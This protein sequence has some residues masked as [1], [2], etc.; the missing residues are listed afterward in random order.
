MRAW[1]LL[2]VISLSVAIATHYTCSSCKVESNNVYWDCS[3]CAMA[4]ASA[5]NK[6]VIGYL[7]GW[8]NPPAASAIAKAGYT[9]ILVAFGVFSTSQPG[10]IVSAFSPPNGVLTKSY[11]AQLQSAG[12]KVLL[13]LGGASS[14]IANTDI[15]FH[16][17]LA[18]ANSP[19][20]FI[21]A[22]VQ[23]TQQI[24]L[25]YGFDGVDFDIEAGLGPTS[26]GTIS[27]PGGDIAVLGQIIVQLHKNNP[28][29]LIS[30]V[31]QTANVSPTSSPIGSIWGNYAAL[32]MQPGVAQALSWVG[33]QLY[34]TGCMN[35]LNGVCY[36][37]TGASP[38]Y[39]VAMAVDLLENWPQMLNGH[40]TG[41]PAYLSYLNIS[42]VV[43]GYPSVNNQ[44]VSDGSPPT[45]ISAIQRS[46]KCLQTATK[47]ST[48]CDT[49]VPPKT[50]GILGGVFNWHVNNDASNNF[51]FASGLSAYFKTL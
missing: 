31:P 32:I 16:N 25:Q 19:A 47:L 44:G 37:D 50:Y 51:Q 26:G 1:Y 6:R 14:G 36:T 42:Q 43:L 11:F 20:A 41:W 2:F 28:N 22:F 12:V 39:G 23:S 35:G 24:I 8:S 29:L 49:Y 4:P 21:S 7:P 18:K 9:H 5:V 48:S 38:D 27:A 40:A 3:A 13:S 30:L 33:V 15:N 45:T 46:I 10:Q 17:V 34:N